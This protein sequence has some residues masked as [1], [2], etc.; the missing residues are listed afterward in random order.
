MNDNIHYLYDRPR[1]TADNVRV[2]F[3]RGAAAG[4]SVGVEE[5]RP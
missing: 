2:G 4:R 1:K 5:L 3:P